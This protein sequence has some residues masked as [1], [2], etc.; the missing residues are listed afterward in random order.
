MKLSERMFEAIG[1]GSFFDDAVIQEVA[2]IEALVDEQN[3]LLDTFRRKLDK[4]EQETVPQ[5]QAENEAL[6]ELT[7]R[8][9]RANSA[10]FYEGGTPSWNLKGSLQEEI[11]ALL[12]EEPTAETPVSDIPASP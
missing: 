9:D 6:R 4:L 8:L 12:K 5:L 11:D 7:G 10:E 2:H 3:K 1:K